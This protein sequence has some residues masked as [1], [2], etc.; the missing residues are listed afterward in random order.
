MPTIAEA[1]LPG[2]AL[3]NWSGLLAPAGTP[4]PIIDR[5]RA[6]IAKALGDPQVKAR[7]A[8]QGIEVITSTPEEFEARMKADMVKWAKVVKDARIKPE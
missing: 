1:A 6:E 2:F 5:L 7:L 4:R 8:P 3:D